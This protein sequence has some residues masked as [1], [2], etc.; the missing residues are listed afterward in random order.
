LV[1]LADSGVVSAAG[2]AQTPEPDGQNPRDALEISG[3]WPTPDDVPPGSP[4]E[5]LRATADLVG[6][7]AAA[8]QTL[9]QASGA[10]TAPVGVLTDEA[11][12]DLVELARTLLA[13][14]D[15]RTGR[16]VD[17]PA[18]VSASGMV[19]LA[20]DRDAFALQ[21]RRPVPSEPTVHARRGTRFHEWVE[22]FYTSAS[23]VDVEDLPGA[24][25]ADLPSDADLEALRER[26]LD[27]EWSRRTPIAV[28]VDV[29]TPLAGVMLRSR[30]DAVFL[31]P[32]APP[33]AEGEPPAVLVVDWKTGR[34]PTDP[35]SR[36]AREV[37][38]A[39]YR[40]AWSRWADVPLEKVS[41]AFCY[42]GSRATVRPERLLTET[43]LEALILGREP[44]GS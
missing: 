34:E 39:V 10:L 6:E 28:E 1:E 24:E 27:S 19:R 16:E 5:V 31:D 21:L 43:E 35:S 17:F 41:A 4:R 32:D 30:I 26:F 29:E 18:H 42:V 23:L 40:L 44:S 12:H 13:E 20:A 8:R 22:Q 14:R 7:A 25:D 37:Q 15:L 9:E 38:L 3:T 11:G 33:P 2:W 36:S